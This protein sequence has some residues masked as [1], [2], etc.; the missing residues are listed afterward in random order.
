[1]YV[2]VHM[3]AVNPAFLFNDRILSR[4]HACVLGIIDDRLF[5]FHA[6][7]C[8]Q[9]MV[10]VSAVNLHR[11]SQLLQEGTL[12][13]EGLNIGLTSIREHVHSRAA[14]I[15]I[16][17]SLSNVKQAQIALKSVFAPDVREPHD[18]RKEIKVL[19][20]MH[21]SNVRLLLLSSCVLAMQTAH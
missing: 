1:M 19:A 16:A 10:Q 13:G 12:H 20:R 17:Q 21:H 8:R 15:Y 5:Y 6:T 18:I 2:L 14:T 11:P 4:S 7:P 9:R 3:Q